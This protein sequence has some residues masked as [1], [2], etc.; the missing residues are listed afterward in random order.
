MKKFF[1]NYHH[2]I[3]IF[4]SGLFVYF[5]LVF[6]FLIIFNFFKSEILQASFSLILP[7][8]FIDSK[9]INATNK[10]LHRIFRFRR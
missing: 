7:I 4:S 8:F 6:L 5:L 1:F 2:K 3:D 9:S 10:L